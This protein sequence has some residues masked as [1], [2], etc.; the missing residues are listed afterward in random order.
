MTDSLPEFQTQQ[1]L[2]FVDDEPNILAALKRLFRSQGYQIFTAESGAQGLEIIAQHKIDLVISDMRMPEMNG[3]QFLEKVRMASPD[4]VRILLTGFADI[5]STVDAINKGQIYRY[6]SKPWE[7]NDISISVRYALEQKQM[8]LE[9]IRLEALIRKQ[10]EELKD[11]NS[12]LEAKVKSRTEELRQ[13]MGFL[14][15]AHDKLKKSFFTSISIFSNLM[16]L[17]ETSM[18]GHSRRVADLARRLAL[19]IGMSDTEAQEVM[20]AGLLH[21]IGKIGFPDY[22]L[23]KSFNTLS[24][25]EREAVVKHPVVGQNALMSLEQLNG[26]AILIRSHHERFDGLGYPDGLAGL[27]IPLG[28]RVLMI[29]NEYESVQL[30]HLLASRMSAQE[31]QHFIQQGR[32]TRYDPQIVDAFIAHM[33]ARDDQVKDR[34]L[35]IR[36]N[37]L[38]RGMILS[39]DLV[40]RGGW[41]LLAKEYEM[42]DAL[43]EQ[44]QKYE[45]SDGH[46]L[47][48]YI[49]LKG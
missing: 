28:A 9:K 42:T 17:R 6:I 49:R 32:G 21:D 35:A 25:E 5:S 7:D 37:Q 36:S 46:T 13:A 4:T 44:L 29:A 24:S 11:L 20:I 8:A 23:N 38:K 40:S 22:L 1:N 30:G 31:A 10:N 41:V 39:R 2:L 14:E 47:T 18:A 45:K 15:V 48:I 43:I 26:A 3:A 16:E 19:R 34:E 27:A 33:S 12:N